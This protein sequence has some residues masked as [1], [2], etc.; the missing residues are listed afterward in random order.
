MGKRQVCQSK[1][2]SGIESV[3]RCIGES[4]VGTGR[5]SS[6]SDMLQNG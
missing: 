1:E 5:G 4:R 6:V 2:K 3:E